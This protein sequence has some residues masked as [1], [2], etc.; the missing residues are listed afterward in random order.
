[1]RSYHRIPAQLAQ[2]N[3]SS[4][5]VHRLVPREQTFGLVVVQHKGTDVPVRP[6]AQILARLDNILVR[7]ERPHHG[8]ILTSPPDPGPAQQMSFAAV[9]PEQSTA[10]QLALEA[11]SRIND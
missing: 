6:L 2:Y 5:L 7:V 10:S 9:A 3:G 11:I 4:A 1:M 8:I